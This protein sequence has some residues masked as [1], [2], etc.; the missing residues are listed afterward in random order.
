MG[1]L[2]YGA[3]ADGHS[4]LA[5]VEQELRE[6]HQRAYD[7]PVEVLFKAD[8]VRYSYTVNADREEYGTTG[9]RVEL[10]AFVVKNR[11]PLGATL[12]HEW[13]GSRRRW[14]DLRP[15][16]LQWASRT[17]LE[18]LEMLKIRRNRQR[19]VLS[20]KLDRCDE[21]IFIVN[22]ELEL[23]HKHGQGVEGGA[24]G[25]AAAGRG[26]AVGYVAPSGHWR[27]RSA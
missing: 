25:G 9:G 7:H 23:A 5:E 16:A 20:H 2:A 14:V 22:A 13:S 21:D 12:L 6:Q 10:F 18:A 3:T 15:N 1:K 17:A 24:A 11:T 8:V 4:S 19:Y 26:S 27:T